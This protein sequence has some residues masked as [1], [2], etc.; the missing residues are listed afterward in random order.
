MKKLSLLA[1]SYVFFL[2]ACDSGGGSKTPV[3]ESEQAYCLSGDVSSIVEGRKVESYDNDRVNAIMLIILG[4]D[5]KIYF[6]TASAISNKVLLTAAHCVDD[7]RAIKVAYKTSAY[8]SSGFDFR[9]DSV[10]AQ[11]FAKHPDYVAKS[12]TNTN[13]D[14]GLVLLKNSIPS[15]YKVFAINQS[16][17]SVNSDL[18]LYGY[19]ITR[20]YNDD[21]GLLR[22]TSVDH[23]DYHYDDKTIVVDRNGDGGICQG[24]SGGPGMIKV[25]S[26]FQIAGVTSYGRGT[27]YDVCSGTGHLVLAYKY[28]PWIKSKMS[29][30]GQYLN[31]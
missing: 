16:P 23:S 28:L 30:W 21:S 12:Y 6:C 24:D 7:A 27:Q 8:C 17:E 18:Y 5:D 4:N 1:L 29:A 25:N 20:G 10:N 9:Y 22:K 14:V 15:P 3:P 31:D 26:E 2:T 13:A 11:S 19:G